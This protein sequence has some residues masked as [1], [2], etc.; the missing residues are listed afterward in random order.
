V[1]QHQIVIMPDVS[2]PV[3]EAPPAMLNHDNNYSFLDE[4]YTQPAG[5]ITTDHSAMLCKKT[6]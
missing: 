3:A 5:L 2:S 1:V 4:A 6:L